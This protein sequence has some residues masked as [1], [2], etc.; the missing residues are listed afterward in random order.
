M[1]KKKKNNTIPGY[2]GT[3]IPG[4]QKYS[5]TRGIEYSGTRVPVYPRYTRVSK[6][7]YISGCTECSGIFRDCVT[8]DGVYGFQYRYERS[9]LLPEAIRIFRVL[10]VRFS[11]SLPTV[12]NS[13]TYVQWHTHK[14][15]SKKNGYQSHGPVSRYWR[16]YDILLR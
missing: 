6:N 5:G 14:N 1:Q 8:P 16:Y 10:C 2:P 3:S 4:F 11:V 15:C 7:Q 12:Y 13:M 9:G